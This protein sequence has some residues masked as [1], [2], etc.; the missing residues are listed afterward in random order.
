[1]RR[2]GTRPNEALVNETDRSAYRRG[3]RVRVANDVQRN[4]FGVGWEAVTD[5]DAAAQV[6]ATVAR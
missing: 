6:A 5:L 2:F 3:I 4:T 1:M